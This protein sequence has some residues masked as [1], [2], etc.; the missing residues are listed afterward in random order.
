MAHILS[1]SYDSTLLMTRELLLQQ[2]GHTV[3]SVED[4]RGHLQPARVVR[5]SIC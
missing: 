5:S 3:T 4:S 1:V 2:M